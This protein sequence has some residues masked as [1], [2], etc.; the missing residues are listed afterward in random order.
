MERFRGQDVMRC[1]FSIRQLCACVIAVSLALGLC[2][3][4]LLQAR[5]HGQAIRAARAAGIRVFVHERGT[6]IRA[7]D[8][9][10]GPY[11]ERRGFRAAANE[12][13]QLLSSLPPDAVLGEPKTY[14][15]RHDVML[16]M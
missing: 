7:D 11:T 2:I 12:T 4:P 14:A 15:E 6:L 13:F 9:T 1:R 16:G 8:T 3:R 10:W 5:R